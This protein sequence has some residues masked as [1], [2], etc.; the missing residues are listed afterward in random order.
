MN[1]DKARPFISWPVLVYDRMAEQRFPFKRKWYRF[2]YDRAT[3]AEI[4]DVIELCRPRH[5]NHLPN[6]EP[7]V[8]GPMQVSFQFGGSYGTDRRILQYRHLFDYVPDEKKLY[9]GVGQ[10]C[11]FWSV[12]LE[13]RTY[14]EDQNEKPITL[15]QVFDEEKE[16]RNGP[17]AKAVVM[18]MPESLL[19]FGPATPIRPQLWTQADADLMAQLSDV[20]GQL[21]RSR[22]LSSRAT[23][24][25]L[26]EKKFH[27]ILPLREDCMAVVLP[28]RQLYSKDGADDL[29]N[30]TCNVH[31]R[32]CPQDHPSHSWITEYQRQFNHFLETPV[33]FPLQDCTLPGRRYLDA[34]AYG[35]GVVHATSKKPEPANDLTALL[36][37]FGQPMVVMAY[38]VLL[39][40]LLQCISMAIPVFWLNV[41][42]WVSDLGWA[43]RGKP[44]TGDVFR[45]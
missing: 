22:W 44:R 10:P 39:R 19:R 32:H 38:H 2:N 33:T 29:F 43:G 3:E 7:V 18:D 30:R 20:H 28:F 6:V 42:H 26:G 8:D 5:D 40:E 45:A 37:Q 23:V 17:G 36:T 12:S 41:N 15:L 35:A 11:A 24:S 34:F 21:V 9:K 14:F 16:R 27:A 25:P 1:A 31:A 4:K 13:P